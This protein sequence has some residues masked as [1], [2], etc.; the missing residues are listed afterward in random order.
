MLGYVAMR[1]AKGYPSGFKCPLLETGNG[2]EQKGKMSWYYLRAH[3]VGVPSGYQTVHQ[4][5][6]NK[7]SGVG[8]KLELEIWQ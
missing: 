8:S 5:F 4:A 6:G 1:E 3:W 2:G 7:R